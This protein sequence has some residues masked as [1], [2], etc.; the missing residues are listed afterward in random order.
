MSTPR[1]S[2]ILIVDDDPISLGLLQNVLEM[3]GYDVQTARDGD[4][5]L[6]L[7]CQGDFR[8]VLSDWQM[9]GISGIEL[10]SRLRKRH[11]SAYVYFILLTCLDRKHNLITGLRAGA[12]DFITKPFDPEELQV[13][14][15]AAERIVS[16]ESRDLLIFSLA[17]LAEWRDPETGAHL[18]RMRVYS[19]ILAHQLSLAP[20]YADV[21]DADYIRT[22]YIA[23]PVHD[24]GKVGIPDHI[25]LKPGRLTRAEFEVMKQH[26]II[27][28]NTLDAALNGHPSAGYLC[29]ARDIAR[30]HHEKYDG[31][32]YPDGLSGEDI[33]LCARI[34]AV[35]DV[36][37]AL[38]TKRVYKDAFSHERAKQ[39]IVDGSGFH[40]DPDL[41][42]A[43][44]AREAD[45]IAVR[46]QF[47]DDTATIE[48][49]EMS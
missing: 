48:A 32:G 31:T 1:R 42:D 3:L 34:V 22:I 24:I 41:V 10:C 14:L 8:I 29:L 20:K 46:E 6:E 37:D 26:S 39:M 12:D 4:E 15:R 33:P 36:Y 25:L 11:L 49:Q 18:E 43:F 16:L 47:N 28:S 40:F 45:F 7:I 44:I 23:S 13:R 38:T 30:S 9:P 35:A 2:P 17:K 19:R 21:V 5:A 27:G